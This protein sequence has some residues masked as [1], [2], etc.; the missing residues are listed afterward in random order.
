MKV[1]K[2]TLIFLTIISLILISLYYDKI[3]KK[4]LNKNLLLY[5]ILI[6]IFILFQLCN[7]RKI[8]TF[9]NHIM[10][11]PFL[12][13]INLNKSPQS[14]NKRSLPYSN[15][16]EIKVLSLDNQYTPAYGL[17]DSSN[18]L[19]DIQIENDTSKLLTD[20]KDSNLANILISNYDENSEF[21]EGSLERNY[22]FSVEPVN[23]IGNNNTDTSILPP[24]NKNINNLNSLPINYSNKDRDIVV[25][26]INNDK[27]NS[28][29]DTEEDNNISPSVSGIKNLSGSGSKGNIEI[30]KDVGTAGSIAINK[31]N[32]IDNTSNTTDTQNHKSYKS[33]YGILDLKS[34]DVKE[35]IKTN[36]ETDET[37]ET[38]ETGSNTI[39]ILDATSDIL[40][41]INQ[42]FIDIYNFIKEI[43]L[44]LYNLLVG[45]SSNGTSSNGTSSNGTS[46]NGTS[47]NGTSS[48]GTSS[49]G[50]N[51]GLFK[52]IEDLFQ[53]IYIFFKD[54]IIKMI[55]F[56]EK[57]SDNTYDFLINNY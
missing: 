18:E 54:L 2:V 49:N 53:S 45:E 8:E 9:N 7:P 50:T 48:N 28:F 55:E 4:K 47:S 11:L 43:L 35:E 3:S 37:D 22:D 12:R 23:Y 51:P 36:N 33:Q 6:F 38:D 52:H 41:K 5:T 20:V 10:D 39:N 14:I 40:E 46:S 31:N 19:R 13:E 32:N 30:E 16:T 17:E 15:T 27:Y 42:I 57:T 24:K 29:F 44:K 25:N 21:I 34:I 26:S 1:N 56:F